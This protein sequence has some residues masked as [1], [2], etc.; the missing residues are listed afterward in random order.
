MV[1]IEEHCEI[2]WKDCESEKYVVFRLTIISLLLIVGFLLSEVFSMI[3]CL[4][5]HL[6]LIAKHLKKQSNI[7]ENRCEHIATL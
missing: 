2:I 7:F 6:Y 1:E 3:L 5:Q 4:I